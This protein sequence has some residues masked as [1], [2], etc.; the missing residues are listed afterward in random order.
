M[1]TVQ[2]ND[3]F[4]NINMICDVM[5]NKARDD[6]REGYGGLVRLSKVRGTNSSRH[7]RKMCSSYTQKPQDVTIEPFLVQKAGWTADL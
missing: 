7:I 1:G 5:T 2:Y 4:M 6:E 3:E